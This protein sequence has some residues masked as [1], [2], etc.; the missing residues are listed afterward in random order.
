MSV[1]SFVIPQ[2]TR[3]TS[4]KGQAAIVRFL[5]HN[6]TAYGV[7]SLLCFLNENKNASVVNYFNARLCQDIFGLVSI[8]FLEA[9]YH[10]RVTLMSFYRKLVLHPKIGARRTNHCLACDKTD[11]KCDCPTLDISFHLFC[12]KP[13]EVTTFNCKKCMNW[14]IPSHLCYDFFFCTICSEHF[15]ETPVYLRKGVYQV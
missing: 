15:K 1:L 3:F 13:C 5:I 7:R 4:K 2:D 10:H 9:V 12:R 11:G 8:A 6:T 14:V